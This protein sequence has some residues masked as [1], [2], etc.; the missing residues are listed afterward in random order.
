MKNDGSQIK[1]SEL[2]IKGIFSYLDGTETKEIPVTNIG[3][4]QPVL[5]ENNS[6]ANQE[7]SKNVVQNSNNEEENTVKENEVAIN[8]TKQEQQEVQNE[9]QQHFKQ[10]V[11][12]VFFRV[13]ICALSQKKRSAYYV[14]RVYKIKKKVYLEEHE[15]WRKYTTGKF[16]AYK[17]ARDYRNYLWSNTPAKDAFITAYNN[18]ER[19]T[20]QEALMVANQKWIK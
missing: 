19:V 3:E 15:G 10:E 8:E 16:A 2:N 13:Q 7:N 1:F 20:V 12:P 14:K 5:A 4:R 17:S 18:G 9:T 11:S 6:Y